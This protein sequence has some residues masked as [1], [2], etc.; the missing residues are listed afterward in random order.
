MAFVLVFVLSVGMHS[1]SITFP[2]HP[3]GPQK[4]QMGSTWAPKPTARPANR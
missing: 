3:V 4:G 2:A 1:I